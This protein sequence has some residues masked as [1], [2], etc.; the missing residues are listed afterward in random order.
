MDRLTELIEKNQATLVKMTTF[1][2]TQEKIIP[3]QENGSINEWNKIFMRRTINYCRFLEQS[4]ELGMFVP[5]KN[6]AP[7]QPVPPSFDGTNQQEYNEYKEAQEKVL[8]KGF[9]FISYRS[10]TCVLMYNDRIEFK[11]SFVNNTIERF[12]KYYQDYYSHQGEIKLTETAKIKIYG[13]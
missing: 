7:L 3:Q 11:V 12:Q 10:M 1:I 4:L 6:G 9:E 2:Q 5:C 8:F 13:K